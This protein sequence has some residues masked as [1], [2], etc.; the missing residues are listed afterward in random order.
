[1]R[2]VEA[3]L[4]AVNQK[5]HSHVLKVNA[6]DSR[7]ARGA[8]TLVEKMGRPFEIGGTRHSSPRRFVTCFST[9]SEEIRNIA[10]DGWIQRVLHLTVRMI[11]TVRG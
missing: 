1:M 2:R 11:R 3:A 5:G 9:M 4:P 6:A 10:R 7:G 8:A